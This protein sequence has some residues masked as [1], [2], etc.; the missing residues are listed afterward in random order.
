MLAPI[1][2]LAA[3]LTAALLAEGPAAGTDVP[4]H[5]LRAA[6]VAEGLSAPLFVTSP[7]AD[8][9]LFVVEQT[10]RIR[11]VRDGVLLAEPWLDLRDR[12]RSGG[13]RGLLGLAFHPRFHENGVFVVDYTDRQGDTRIV[14]F[15]AD[16]A[17]ARADAASAR[18][19]LHVEQPYANHN[20]GMVAFGP[21]GMLWI[22]MGDGG[23]AGDPHDN[24]QSR[25]TLLGKLLRIDVDRGSPYAIPRDNPWPATPGVRP[26]I[27]ATGLRNPWRFGFDAGFLY[28]G[29]VGQSDWEEIDVARADAPGLDY[30]WNRREGA[31]DYRPRGPRVATRLVDPVLEY[32]HRE[33]CCVIGGAV[34][35]GSAMPDLAGT[36]FYSDWCE[37][38]LRSFRWNGRAATDRR[39]WDV[40]SLG[41]VTSFGTDARGEVYVTTQQGRLLRLER[42]N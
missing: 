19:I 32:S 28:I 16:P 39:H 20:G 1:A 37:G 15:H 17:S 41:S 13:E 3:V 27:W 6:V 38:W 11:I 29:D 9:R 36:Y 40:G 23:S 33:G 12:L 18:E 24:G 14:R 8:A 26:E 35:R 5:G 42:S 30:G 4:S 10:G 25:A 31:H 21:D 7:P 2:W 34:Y 22:G